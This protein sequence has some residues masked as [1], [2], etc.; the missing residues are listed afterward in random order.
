MANIMAKVLVLGG[1]GFI[2]SNIAKRFIEAKNEVCV[3]DGLLDKTGGR[4][5]EAAGRI[6]EEKGRA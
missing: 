3:I 5:E 6:G 2:G 1:A 4:K